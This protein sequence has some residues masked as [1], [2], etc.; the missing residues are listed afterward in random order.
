MRVLARM[1]PCADS[2]EPSLLERISVIF[3]HSVHN[4][5]LLIMG[6]DKHHFERIIV[7]IFLPINF[8]LCLGAQK[9][10]LIETLLLSTHNISFV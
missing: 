7:N 5:L 2:Y 9:N 4:H 3:R 10:R 1:C 6:L 8:N